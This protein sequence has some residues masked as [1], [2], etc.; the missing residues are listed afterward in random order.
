MSR[1]TSL[2]SAGL[3]ASALLA[4][5]LGGASARVVSDEASPYACF[6]QARAVDASGDVYDPIGAVFAS[7]G[8]ANAEINLAYL[9]GCQPQAP[10]PGAKK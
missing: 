1:V 4:G 10:D 6:G 2:A 5:S 3:I 8:D 9:E 7:R